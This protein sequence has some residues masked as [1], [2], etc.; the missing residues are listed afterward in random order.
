M[1]FEGD[2]KT[3]IGLING[4]EKNFGLY[5]WICD[6]K[7][8]Q[9]KF[10]ATEVCWVPCQS[11]QAADQLAKRINRSLLFTSYFYVPQSIVSILHD[12]YIVSNE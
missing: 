9:S 3:V 7:F 2:N 5:N 12:D 8:W 1:I 6:I 4:D 11:N 10:Q